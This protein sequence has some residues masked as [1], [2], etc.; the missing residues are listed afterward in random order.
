VCCHDHASPYYPAS[1]G[2]QDYVQALHDIVVTIVIEK[3]GTVTHLE[4]VLAMP[5]VDMVQWAGSDYSMRI[6]RAVE[7]R[8][9]E[10][11]LQ[12]G[13]P[14]RAEINSADEEKYFLDMGVRHFCIGTD[15]N[16]LY[17][18]CRQQGDALRK[19]LSGA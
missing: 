6:G 2:I 19:M 13:V 7:H 15:I 14:P 12:K 8:V 5:G 9:V 1:G 11:A 17:D 3:P 18:W 4:E 16:I 10:T